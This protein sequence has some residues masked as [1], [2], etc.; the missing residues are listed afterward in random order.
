MSKKKRANT[1]DVR[2]TAEEKQG[3]GM[4]AEIAGISLSDWVRERLRL[5][6]IREL[7]G[8]G[9]KVPFIPDIP[10]SGRRECLT[11]SRR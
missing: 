7:E 4:C 5:S 3:F 1:L 2:L 8:A 9:R 6:A 11:G 10:L